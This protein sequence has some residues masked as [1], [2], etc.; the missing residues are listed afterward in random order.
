M[1]YLSLLFSL[2]L[3][4]GLIYWYLKS[5][6][7]APTGDGVISTAPQQ[8]IKQAE[9]SAKLL[10]QSLQQQQQQIEQAKPTN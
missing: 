9:E 2:V 3:I 8:T 5:G 4:A 10:Q 6:A 1:R 7:T